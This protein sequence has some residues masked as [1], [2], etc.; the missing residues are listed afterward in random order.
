MRKTVHK[1][2]HL[3]KMLKA[4][5]NRIPSNVGFTKHELK[6]LTL[7]ENGSSYLGVND[8]VN[9]SLL[10]WTSASCYFFSGFTEQ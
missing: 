7:T 9:T 5:D 6:V 4:C 8:P 10:N 3:I 1:H 2:L